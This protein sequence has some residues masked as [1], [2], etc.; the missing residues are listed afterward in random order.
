MKPA[1]IVCAPIILISCLERSFHKNK[2]IIF[3]EMRRRRS[4]PED[5]EEEEDENEDDVFV[6]F[7][8]SLKP[9]RSFQLPFGGRINAQESN[10]WLFVCNDGTFSVVLDADLEEFARVPFVSSF[11]HSGILVAD[12]KHIIVWRWSAKLLTMQDASTGAVIFS[13]ESEDE[14]WKDWSS[15]GA[16]CALVGRELR[17]YRTRSV[18]K[19]LSLQCFRVPDGELLDEVEVPGKLEAHWSIEAKPTPDGEIR[20]LLQG[21]AGQDGEEHFCFLHTEEELVFLEGDESGRNFIDV[22]V[23]ETTYG[24]QSMTFDRFRF[25]TSARTPGA[26]HFEE[27]DCNFSYNGVPL[28][29]REGLLVVGQDENRLCLVEQQSPTELLELVDVPGLTYHHRLYRSAGSVVVA[30][31]EKAMLTAWDASGVALDSTWYR[32]HWSPLT[33]RLLPRKCRDAIRTLMLCCLRFEKRVP[34]DMRNLLAAWVAWAY[35]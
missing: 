19:Q 34:R 11:N 17:L 23:G 2:E 1:R 30:I 21:Y 31:D 8:S 35:Q 9:I 14:D 22:L 27:D 15:P 24:D 3:G 33:H 12:V 10:G 6:L 25:R 32:I 18:G 7:S 16:A 4:S 13:L 26:V 20:V 5:E 28:N 29:R